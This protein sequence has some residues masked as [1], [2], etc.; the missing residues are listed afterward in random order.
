MCV[1]PDKDTFSLF[2]KPL[3]SEYGE[4]QRF[5]NDGEDRE[6]WRGFWGIRRVEEIRVGFLRALGGGWDRQDG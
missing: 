2:V 1:R 3:S 5:R 4:D 6:F